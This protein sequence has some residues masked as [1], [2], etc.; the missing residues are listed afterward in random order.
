MTLS[1]QIHLPGFFSPRKTNLKILINSDLGQAGIAGLVSSY[2]LIRFSTMFR[3]QQ[4]KEDDLP[5]PSQFRLVI[6]RNWP[7]PG[8]S[9]SV[10]W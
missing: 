9:S 4:I 7:G 2:P 10:I 6:S 3:R 5:V 8:K 1:N